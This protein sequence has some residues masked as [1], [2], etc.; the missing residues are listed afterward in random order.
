M[1][2]IYHVE[3]HG[4]MNRA[5]LRALISVIGKVSVRITRRAV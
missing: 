5:E 4:E 2:T 1:V 3:G